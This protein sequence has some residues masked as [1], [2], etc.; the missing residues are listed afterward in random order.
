MRFV[1]APAPRVEYLG[2]MRARPATPG[3]APAIAR[4]YSEGIADRVATF[5]TEPRTEEDVRAWFDGAHPIVVVEDGDSGVVGFASTFG[6]RP[7]EC[8]SGIAEFAVYVARGERRRGIGTLAMQEL[9]TLC[10]AVGFWKL[11]SRVF[12]DNDA[13]RGLLQFIGFREVGTYHRHAKLDGVWRDV[14][15]VEKFLAPIPQLR[16][17]ESTK[18]ATGPRSGASSRGSAPPTRSRAQRP[19]TTRAPSSSPA[20][21]TLSCSRPR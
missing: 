2:R 13:S 6:Y 7:R 15:I 5:E 21:R 17:V 1:P 11:L 14:V 9:I 16:S 12:V 8:Y 3:D 20:S 10:R 4:V 18:L 19:S